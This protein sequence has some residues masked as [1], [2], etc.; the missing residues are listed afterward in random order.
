MIPV[1]DRLV[2]N[3][4]K[5]VNTNLFDAWLRSLLITILVPEIFFFLFVIAAGIVSGCPCNVYM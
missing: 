5:N 4:W 1:D 3:V 2:R